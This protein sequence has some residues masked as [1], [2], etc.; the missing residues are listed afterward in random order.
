MKMLE[1]ANPDKDGENEMSI[2]KIKKNL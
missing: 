2:K 1:L